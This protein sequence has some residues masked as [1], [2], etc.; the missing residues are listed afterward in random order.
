MWDMASRS[1][2]WTLVISNNLT[3]LLNRNGTAVML[4]TYTPLITRLCDDMPR[5]FTRLFPERLLFLWL[6]PR[7]I[8]GPLFLYTQ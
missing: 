8:H 2:A 7:Q 6:F 5:A 4:N 1:A 3:Q